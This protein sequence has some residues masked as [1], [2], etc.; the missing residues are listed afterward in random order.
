[1]ALFKNSRTTTILLKIC[2]FQ[3]QS[4]LV[5]FELTAC[6]S[7]VGSDSDTSAL[8]TDSISAFITRKTARFVSPENIKIQSIHISQFTNVY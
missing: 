1:M 2:N 5:V 7:L 6:G 8:V 4:Q 3:S